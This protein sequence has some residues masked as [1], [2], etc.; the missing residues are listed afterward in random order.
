MP[1][2]VF[3]CRKNYAEFPLIYH[4][5]LN[6]NITI[7]N[8]KNI[9]Y[10]IWNRCA[11]CSLNNTYEACLAPCIRCAD[12]LCD[13]CALSYINQH[14]ISSQLPMISKCWTIVTS[15]TH[16]PAAGNCDVTMT[17]CSRVVSIDAFISQWR[18]DQRFK[19]FVKYTSVPSFSSLIIEKNLRIR[20]LFGVII[21]CRRATSKTCRL[22]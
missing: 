5:E 13:S 16:E 11:W 14:F 2:N 4:H 8:V 21:N 12:H 6:D 20:K 15:S 7:I 10:L 19:E 9:C 3:Q 18:W 17:Y 22:W 1:L